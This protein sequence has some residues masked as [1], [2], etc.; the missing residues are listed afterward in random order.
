[1]GEER[2][3]SGGLRQTDIGG[4]EGKGRD[5]L[6]RKVGR[7]KIFQAKHEDIGDD[8]QPVHD[9][10]SG[11]ADGISNRDHGFLFAKKYSKPIQQYK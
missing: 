5:E 9:R 1:M 6:L 3:Q 11:A 10:K 2:Q 8:D 4:S 7:Q